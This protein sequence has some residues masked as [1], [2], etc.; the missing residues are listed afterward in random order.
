MATLLAE[1]FARLAVLGIVDLQELVNYMSSR[2]RAA[3]L[4]YLN[5]RDTIP[6]EERMAFRGSLCGEF[7]K[8]MVVLTFA[9]VQGPDS[10]TPPPVFRKLFHICIAHPEVELDMMWLDVTVKGGEGGPDAVLSVY[11]EA[12]WLPGRPRNCP[13]LSAIIDAWRELEVFMVSET[14]KSPPSRL[15]LSKLSLTRLREA[16]SLVQ[17]SLDLIERDLE[18]TRA[19]IQR[20]SCTLTEYEREQAMLAGKGIGSLLYGLR[21]RSLEEPRY[22]GG[23]AHAIYLHHQRFCAHVASAAGQAKSMTLSLEERH[24]LFD[25]VDAEAE[26]MFVSYSLLICTYSSE[27]GGPSNPPFNPMLPRLLAML[28]T[29]G[30]TQERLFSG[31]AYEDLGKPAYDLDSIPQWAKMLESKIFTWVSKGWPSDVDWPL[32]GQGT[33]PTG[34]ADVEEA[35]TL[36]EARMRFLEEHWMEWSATESWVEEALRVS[37]RLDKRWTGEWASN[38]EGWI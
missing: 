12:W 36:L 3:G 35:K 21:A 11:K 5:L 26:G 37:N 8:T 38:A 20:V 28:P 7:I 10:I 4:S 2:L 6:E 32:E 19:A 22:L 18:E 16:R 24:A 31:S 15:V 9:T 1:P 17:S 34:Y 30:W 27:G 13:P 23:D 29:G 25:I 33:I 14:P